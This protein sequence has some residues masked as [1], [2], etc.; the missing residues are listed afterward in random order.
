V[1]AAEQCFHGGLQVVML[2][3]YVQP[4]ALSALLLHHVCDLLLLGARMAAW[5]RET[6]RCRYY[7]LFSVD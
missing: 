4:A 2:N 3:A 7:L 5:G 1:A 6:K